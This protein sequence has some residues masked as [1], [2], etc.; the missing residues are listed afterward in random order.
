[1]DRRYRN[2]NEC[3]EDSRITNKRVGK[4][5]QGT[6]Y[7]ACCNETEKKSSEDCTHLVKKIKITSARQ[8]EKFKTEVV[9]Q[10]LAAYYGFA[11]KI[12]KCWI[13]G[14]GKNKTGFFIME[15]MDRSLSDVLNECKYDEEKTNQ[16]FKKVDALIRKLHDI[17]IFHGDIHLDNVMVHNGKYKI[18]DF[19]DAVLKEDL[20]SSDLKNEYGRLAGSEYDLFEKMVQH[21]IKSK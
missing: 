2:T 17:S 1:M 8:L 9:L 18:I 11:P 21:K 12:F 13:E 6:V 5:G 10:S 3:K 19:G 14:D 7:V 4:G 20:T 16:V 15:K